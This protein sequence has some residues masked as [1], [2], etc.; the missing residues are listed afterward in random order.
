MLGFVIQ[1]LG[2]VVCG[3]WSVVCGLWFVVCGLWFVVCLCVPNSLDSD[4]GSGFEVPR[5]RTVPIET[6]LQGYLT[7]KKTHPPTTLT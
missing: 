5:R 6:A 1:G 7:C 3:V 2:S 4:E